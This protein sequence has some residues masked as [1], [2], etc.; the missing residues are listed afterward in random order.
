MASDS[1]WPAQTEVAPWAS[2]RTAHLASLS[3]GGASDDSTRAGSGDGRVHDFHGMTATSSGQKLARI[4]AGKDLVEAARPI[5]NSQSVAADSA[6]A[7]DV[8]AV[9]QSVIKPVSFQ[10][11]PGDRSMTPEEQAAANRA[12]WEEQQQFSPVPGG[13]RPSPGANAQPAQPNQNPQPVQ[14]QQPQQVPAT[15]TPGAAKPVDA[16]APAQ[17]N[18]ADSTVPAPTLPAEGVPWETRS[19]NGA[20]ATS[21]IVPGTG[22]QTIDT[23]IRNADG[24]TTQVRSVSD[25]NGGVTTWTANADGS[26]SVRYPDGTNG[27]PPNQ[28]KIYTVPAGQDSS[29]PAPISTDISADGKNTHTESVNPDGTVSQADSKVRDDG[30]I[31]TD[32]LNPNG[33]TS[34]TVA[35]PGANGAITTT[36]ISDIDPNG[37]G[38]DTDDAG[39]RWDV[40]PTSREGFDHK[41]LELHVQRKEGDNFREEIFDKYGHLVSSELYGPTGSLIYGRTVK[42]DVEIVVGLASDV[43]KKASDQLARELMAAYASSRDKNN[44]DT[45]SPSYLAAQQLSDMLGN[46]PGDDN[47]LI[48]AV[49]KDGKIVQVSIAGKDGIDHVVSIGEKPGRMSDPNRFLQFDLHPDGSMIDG[50]GNHLVQVEGSIIRYGPDGKPVIPNSSEARQ[51]KIVK[52][53][54]NATGKYEFEVEP[55]LFEY[56][57]NRRFVHRPDTEVNAEITEIVPKPPGVGA[58]KVYK[59]A[60]GGVLI[61]DASGIHWATDPGHGPSVAEQLEALAFELATLAVLDGAGRIAFRAGAKVIA[62]FKAREAAALAREAAAAAAA[63][64]A[65]PS[66]AANTGRAGI[67]DSTAPFSWGGSAAANPVPRAGL[68]TEQPPVSWRGSA[69][70]PASPRAALPTEQPPASWGGSAASPSVPKVSQAPAP[71]SA[72]VGPARIEAPAAN[73]H[74]TFPNHGASVPRQGAEPWS[75]L[76]PRASSTV[77]R[78]GVPAPRIAELEVETELGVSTSRSRPPA[79]PTSTVGRGAELTRAGHVAAEP[80]AAGPTRL[81]RK[82]GKPQKFPKLPPLKGD[83][84]FSEETT[85]AIA[86]KYGIDI[87]DIRFVHYR[88]SIRGLGYGE[89]TSPHDVTLYPE[90]FRKGA[91]FIKV[92]ANGHMDVIPETIYLTG[93]ARLARTLYHEKFHAD[94]LKQLGMKRPPRNAEEVL[95]FEIRAWA[96][97]N[98][99]WESVGKYIHDATGK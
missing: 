14:N 17:P 51:P 46:L 2:A 15:T 85:I 52:Y 31:R 87:S 61:E 58:D 80:V 5:A 30:T 89:T 9:S 35:T 22:G 75:D 95:Q 16:P 82:G 90:A 99:W 49:Y 88:G 34:S 81:M 18:P 43:R 25:G 59:V 74:T 60:G 37:Y 98:E 33:S 86:Q 68:P 10:T 7:G 32:H 21:V 78:A 36:L 23:T 69:V 66:I 56:T 67:P 65:A 28:A 40:T 64:K 8:P 77:P 73:P 76:P 83:L 19:D 47:A 11:G 6:P 94:E 79:G 63:Q 4:F 12:R 3:A 44:P 27:A 50:R 96:A 45:S 97:E 71:A 72:R 92:I 29:G 13:N 84:M 70:S 48:K 24:T 54:I 41:A 62:A 53:S 55:K 91:E 42:D 26:L 20:V 1:A 39:I 57:G 38:Y 93:E